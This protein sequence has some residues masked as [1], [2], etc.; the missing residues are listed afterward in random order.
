MDLL[1]LFKGLHLG[2]LQVALWDLSRCHSTPMTL[3]LFAQISSTLEDIH[4]LS[5]GKQK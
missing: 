1:V 5:L 4:D 3:K 2:E